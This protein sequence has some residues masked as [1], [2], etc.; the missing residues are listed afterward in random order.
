MKKINN[1]CNNKRKQM[2]DYS[3]LEKF[4]QEHYVSLRSVAARFVDPNTAQDITQNVIYK[5]LE[6]KEQIDR[7][8]NLDNFLFTMIKN[9]A[10]TYLRSAKNENKKYDNLSRED[11]EAPEVLHIMIE[12]ETNQILM[13]AIDQLPPQTAHIMR[14][15]LSG[16]DNKEIATLVNISLNT[17]K[18]LKYGGIR[19]LREYFL[20]HPF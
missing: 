14:L 3:K 16:Y 8:E 15:V 4:I 12:E 1:I 9:E 13:N 17:V 20:S 19:R 5:F 6:K 7:I 11:A 18:T 10:L 2:K